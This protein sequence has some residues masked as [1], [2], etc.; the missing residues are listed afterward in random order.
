MLHTSSFCNECSDCV[1]SVLNPSTVTS[2]N[3]RLMVS[4]NFWIQEPVVLCNVYKLGCNM[5]RN[6]L[7]SHCLSTLA[8]IIAITISARFLANHVITSYVCERCRT[9]FLQVVVTSSRLRFHDIVTAQKKNV[10]HGFY[11]STDAINFNK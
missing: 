5:V 9:A 6:D 4:G 10:S 3:Q 11:F 8:L 7:A 2:S 1:F